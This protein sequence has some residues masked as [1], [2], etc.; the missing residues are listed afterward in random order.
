VTESSRPRDQRRDDPSRHLW[1]DW[2][3]L[4]AHRAVTTF[5]CA[6]TNTLLGARVLRTGLWW[7]RC[8]GRSELC[9][10]YRRPARN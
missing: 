6:I 8:T 5:F 7:A 2:S 3:Q 1:L 4:I 10:L 9:A